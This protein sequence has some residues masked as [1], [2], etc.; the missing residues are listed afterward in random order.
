MQSGTFL[1][2]PGENTRDNSRGKHWQFLPQP[3]L[4][5]MNLLGR[6][7]FRP[8]TYCASESQQQSSSFGD[9]S[10]SCLG[11]AKKGAQCALVRSQFFKYKRIKKMLVGA[12]GIEPT[13]FGLKGRCSTTELRPSRECIRFYRA[14]VE[15]AT[16]DSPQTLY[17]TYTQ[18][19]FKARQDCARENQ[20]A[21]SPRPACVS[22]CFETVRARLR[23]QT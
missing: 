9:S 22:P 21:A 15:P 11:T 4:D 23:F 1:I 5:E 3:V 10:A 13:T 17:R 14:R 7:R 19:W 16:R 8:Q 6:L 2:R 12:V 18:N 20:S